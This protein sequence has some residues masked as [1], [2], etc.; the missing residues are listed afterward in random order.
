MSELPESLL[1]AAILSGDADRF[2]DLMG[3]YRGALWRLAR[4]RLGDDALAEDAV[5][6]TF[7]NAFKSLHT[8]DSRF[9]FRT[10][11]W[12]ILLNQ[13]RR[14]LG[15]IQRRAELSNASDQVQQALFH[16]QTQEPGPLELVLLRE[17]ASRLG[18]LLERLPEAEADALRLRFFGDLKFQEIA[19]VL[20][21]SL[22]TA[23]NRVREGL[24]QLAR[25]LGQDDH[26]LTGD[27][28]ERLAP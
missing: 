7:L 2:A 11:L 27:A 21:C 9:S 10:W 8:Y 13:C 17:Q 26:S 15:K 25:W 5:Q 19:D 28:E 1:I 3:R 16:Q 4:N 12:T 18:R 22:S 24:L 23:K 14:S 20:G 6:D